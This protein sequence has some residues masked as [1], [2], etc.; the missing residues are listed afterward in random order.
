MV[1][2]MEGSA[3]HAHIIWGLIALVSLIYGII[4]L[5]DYEFSLGIGRPPIFYV[6][7]RENFARVMG[8]ALIIY[9]VINLLT[10][11]VI[12]ASPDTSPSWLE[13]T[14]VGGFCVLAFIF[15]LALVLTVCHCAWSLAS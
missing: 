7:L 10:I 11:L 15:C 4:T 5:K 6:S 3:M 14:E 9:G 2:L 1:V 13:V 12:S 8:V